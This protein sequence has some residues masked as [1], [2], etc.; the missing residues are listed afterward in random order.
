SPPDSAPDAMRG[1]LARERGD[2]AGVVARV[3]PP[4]ATRLAGEAVRPLEPAPLHPRGRLP[5]DPGV[6]VEGGADA[7]EDRGV[8]AVAHL[9][10]PLFLLR[11]A[12]AAQGDVGAGRVDARGDLVALVVCERPER[13]R[14]PA[15]DP[16]P[17]VAGEQ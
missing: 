1:V 10:H 8:E 11:L 2:E 14:P 3:A 9:G 7:R 15:D 5:D 13:R 4:E 6:E 17:R 16:Q 12:R